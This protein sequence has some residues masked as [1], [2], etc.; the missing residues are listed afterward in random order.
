MDTITFPLRTGTVPVSDITT[1]VAAWCQGRGD[2]LVNVFLPH[3]TC[4][5]ALVETGAGSEPDLQRALAGLLPRDAGWQHAHGSPGHGADHVL[6]AFVSPSLMVP[7][8]DG[9]PALGR[10]QSIVIVDT[11]VDNP[12]RTVR[13]SFMPI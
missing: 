13:L 8:I 10:W 2:G 12:D 9:R 3:A 1:R 4:G 11:N 6:P 7:V 5:V